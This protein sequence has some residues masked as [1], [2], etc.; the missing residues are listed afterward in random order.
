MNKTQKSSENLQ[1][2]FIHSSFRTGSTWLWFKFRE[3]L[4]C[5][6]YYEIFNEILGE[7]N[8]KSIL[9]SAEDWNSHHPQGAPYFSEFS[10]LLDKTEGIDGFDQDL[11]LTDFFLSSDG[12]KD[13]VRRTEAYLARLVNLAQHNKRVPVL[14]CTRSIGRIKLIRELIGGTHIL[15]RRRLL[16][17]WFSYSNQALNKNTFFFNT[18]IRTVNARD[19]DTFIGMLANLL[20]DNGISQNSFGEDHDT[21]LIVFLCLHIYLYAKHQSDFDI[22]IDFHKGSFRSDLDMATRLI[23]EVT[24][25]HVNLSDYSETISAPVMLIQDVDR[26]FSMVRS[27]FAKPIPGLD[28]EKLR[29]LVDYELADFR[30]G[31]EQY[32][33]IAGSAHTQLKA[34]AIELSQLENACKT[35]DNELAAV[36]RSAQQQLEELHTHLDAATDDLAALSR[37]SKKAELMMQQER[38]SLDEQSAQLK[39]RLQELEAALERSSADREAQ[40]QEIERY[41]QAQKSAE[42]ALQEE[43]ERSAALAHDLQQVKVHEAELINRLDAA[44]GD[45]ADVTRQFKEAEL[46]IQDERTALS[47]QASQSVERLRDLK[48]KLQGSTTRSDELERDLQQASELEAE[49]SVRLEALTAEVASLRSQVTVAELAFHEERAQKELAWAKLDFVATGKAKAQEDL[50]RRWDSMIKRI[51]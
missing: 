25:V 47:D 12:D 24:G 35:A 5:Y 49:L 45:L 27:L 44:N 32:R 36:H 20:K 2:V 16:N 22:I 17:Q 42:S 15:I 39:E 43:R 6:C 9:Q 11:A 7:I 19:A 46:A 41:M 40:D 28:Y 51:R 1:T 48:A 3:Q 23:D 4:D 50:E 38:A 18:V 8:F 26:V 14:S 29:T 31:Y 13:R 10:P 30:Q 37:E 34:L 21:L 33:Q